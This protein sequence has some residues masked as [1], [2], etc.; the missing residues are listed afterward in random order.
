MKNLNFALVFALVFAL[1]TQNAFADDITLTGEV[2]AVAT[3]TL[4]G[5]TGYDSLDLTGAITDQAVVSVDELC[6]ETDGYTVTL[7]SLNDDVGKLFL[8]NSDSGKKVAYTL[9]YNS[10]GSFVAVNFGGGDTATISDK[11]AINDG[12]PT[13]ATY[14]M[15]LSIVDDAEE[16]TP[17]SGVFGE[18]DLASLPSGSYTDTLTFTIAAK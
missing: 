18:N 15:K 13:A 11:S 5:E 3:V 9:T 10:T 17:N 14:S 2:T 16:T 1:S 7:D 4:T 12:Y 6:N 8:L